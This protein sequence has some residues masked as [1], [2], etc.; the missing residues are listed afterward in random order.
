MLHRF[1]Y[2]LPYKALCK[3]KKVKWVVFHGACDFAYLLKLVIGN[4]LLPRKIEEY[5]NFLQNYF[6]NIYDLKYLIEFSKKYSKSGLSH[7][8]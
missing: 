5:Q 4:E 3:N 2:D 7:L 6:D 8:G 1:M